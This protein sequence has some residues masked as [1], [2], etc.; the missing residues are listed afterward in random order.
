MSSAVSRPTCS[1]GRSWVARREGLPTSKRKSPPPTPRRVQDLTSAARAELLRRFLLGLVTAL[2]VARPVV[3]G[4]DPGLLASVSHPSGMV[5]TLL[6]LVAAVGWAAWH[7]WSGRPWRGSWVEIGLLATVG[8]VALSGELTASYK[9]PARLIS[10]EWLALLVAFCL[11]RQLARA[12]GDNRGLLAALLA[13]GVT[14]AAYGVFQYTVEFPQARTALA[15]RTRLRQELAKEN[16]FLDA[17]PTIVLPEDATGLLTLSPHAGFPAGLPWGPLLLADQPSA[18][19]PDT[20]LAR[21]EERIQA[22][23]AFAT[24]SHPNSFAG[25]LALLLPAAV[26]VAVASRRGEGLTFRYHAPLA[27]ACAGL[28]GLALWLTHSRGALLGVLVAGAALAGVLGRTWLL[29][30]KTWVAAGVVGAA[31]LGGWAW[32]S[33]WLNELLGKDTQTSSRRLEYWAATWAMIAE[34][35][36]LGVGSG[37]FGRHYPRYLPATAFE[38]IQDPHNF[39]LEMWACSGLF[40]AAAL[41]GTFAVFFGRVG[42]GADA[43][44]ADEQVAEE[45]PTGLRWEFYLGGVCGLLLGFILRASNMSPDLIFMEGF[46][47]GLRSVVWFVAFAVLDGVLWRGPSQPLVLAAGVLALLVNLLVSGGISAPSVAQ[48]LW[49]VAALALN[50]AGPADPAAAPAGPRTWLWRLLPV[51]ALAVVCL[52]YALL[53]FGPVT[54]AAASVADAKRFYLEWHSLQEPEWRS[55][56]TRSEREDV[57]RRLSLSA[58]SYLQD[59]IIKKLDAAV[60]EDPRNAASWIELSHWEG[61]RWKVLARHEELEN[62]ALQCAQYAS[63]LDPEGKQGYLATHRL[64]RSFAQTVGEW[65]KAA[66]QLYG[67]AAAALAEVVKRDPN[68][69]G[70]RFQLA[71][72]HFLAGN[73]VEGREAAA[74]ALKLDR[75]AVA[76]GRSVTER[77]LSRRQHLQAQR[78]LR[79]APGK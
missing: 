14:L 30:H 49:I 65:G 8:C 43:P 48:P 12:P 22:A 16:V 2:I 3:L 56:Y 33:G 74:E 36:W 66:P 78:W 53:T 7:Y 63:Q 44:A 41:L 71:E 64:Y 67:K 39:V 24:Y 5:L 4:E 1:G 69:A 60:R 77:G 15:D 50:T 73:A 59:K 45:A 62:K 68:D 47:A 42:R 76:A 19:E 13:T 58:N 61:E 72:C 70:L 10:W 32:Q 75:Q 21:W 20:R 34:H 54:N 46:L 52:A 6:W 29:R 38:K 25:F 17:D 9:H 55:R 35:P 79:Q 28:I 18:A 23:N 31:A 11:V 57:R 40:A 26:G 51:P 27:V 37:N